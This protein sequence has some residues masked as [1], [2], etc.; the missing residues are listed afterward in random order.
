MSNRP[1]TRRVIV[2]VLAAL[3]G[4]VVAGLLWIARDRAGDLSPWPTFEIGKE[5]STVPGVSL[6]AGF[7]G[8]G[9]RIVRYDSAKANLHLGSTTFREML[10]HAY[11]IPKGGIAWKLNPP[12][13]VFDL[14]AEVSAGGKDELAKRLREAFGQVFRIRGTYEPRHVPVLVLKRSQTHREALRIVAGAGDSS[15]SEEE[16]RGSYTCQGPVSRLADWLQ[17]QLRVPV[18]DETGVTEYIWVRLSWKEDPD[19]EL[20]ESIEQNG[21]SLEK[22]IRTVETLVIS[23]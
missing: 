1:S 19:E 9:E 18:L 22:A 15:D 3:A 8:V 2:G 14:S 13:G 21:L 23:R 12:E 5:I 7:D 6:K 11:S 17:R 16:T 4:L 20:L 10:E